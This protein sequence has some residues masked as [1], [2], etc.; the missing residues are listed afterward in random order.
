M[1]SPSILVT[2]LYWIVRLAGLGC[3]RCFGVFVFFPRSGKVEVL[4]CGMVW[5]LQCVGMGG[6][7]NLNCSAHCSQA[8]FSAARYTVKYGKCVLLST[9][10]QAVRKAMKV[11]DFSGNGRRWSV[12]FD[13]QDLGG[14]LD[15]TRRARLGRVLGLSGYVLPPSVWQQWV[16]CRWWFGLSSSSR[17]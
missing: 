4:T 15:F 5:G 13:V 6:R 10:F 12:E 7:D 8:L 2:G 17:C 9:F 11:W 16:R 3:P 14:H 1:S